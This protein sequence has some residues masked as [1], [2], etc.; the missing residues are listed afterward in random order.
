M[1]TAETTVNTIGNC[2]T[3][4]DLKAL[5]QDVRAEGSNDPFTSGMRVLPV[6]AGDCEVFVT[7][8]PAGE[9][10]HDEDRGDTWIFVQEGSLRLLAAGAEIDLAQG[11]SLVVP[12]GRRFGWRAQAPARL[13]GM[14][15][16]KA[17]EGEGQIARIDNSAPLAPSNPPADDVLLGETPSCRSGNQFAS[18]DGV[19][20]CGI[21]DSTPYRRLPIHFH[22]SELM[23]LL[24]G[25]VTFTDA[26]GRT[27]TFAKGDTFIIEKGADCSWDSAE[28]VAKIYAYYR[29]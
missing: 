1:V 18:S 2:P 5:S 21:W 20:K 29:A 16:L 11:E 6:R 23:H 13:I 10:M 27:A 8:V 24:D 26:A 22:H 19:F 14:R 4:I 9:G 25:S 28:Y 7:G 15:Y 12:R 3:F 17:P